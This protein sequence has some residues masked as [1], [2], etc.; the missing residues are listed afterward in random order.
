MASDHHGKGGGGCGGTCGCGGDAAGAAVAEAPMLSIDPR[1]DV[2]EVPH[3][4]RHATVFAALESVPVE[5]ALVLVAP[6]APRPLL[7]QIQDLFPG[8]FG[9]EWLQSGPEVWQVR[10]QRAATA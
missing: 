10:L 3:D 9:V 5:G 1:I 2:R 8:Q 6:H 4:R 7:N